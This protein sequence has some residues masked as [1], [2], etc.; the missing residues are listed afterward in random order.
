MPER[1][2]IVLTASTMKLASGVTPHLSRKLPKP[3]STAAQLV[4]QLPIAAMAFKAAAKT[5]ISLIRRRMVICPTP[6]VTT[7]RFD[8]ESSNILHLQDV[9]FSTEQ[10]VTPYNR[11]VGRLLGTWPCR[12]I[13]MKAYRDIRDVFKPSVLFYQ[14][15]A[16]WPAHLLPP[17]AKTYI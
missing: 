7:R 2:T 5:D 14:L 4:I 1:A 16:A 8:E 17:F 13:C 9:T 3:V 10:L 15:V 12:N 6:S 11:V